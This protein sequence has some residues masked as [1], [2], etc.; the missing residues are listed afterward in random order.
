MTQIDS[1]A[2]PRTIP[3]SFHRFRMFNRMAAHPAIRK[4]MAV[5]FE[6][7]ANAIATP[8]VTGRSGQV[9]E[10]SRVT[11]T[12]A[13]K[14]RWVLAIAARPRIGGRVVK[15]AVAPSA[16]FGPATRRAQRKTTAEAI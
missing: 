11:P 4:G 14:A 16:A 13:H 7:T 12:I 1:A 2:V 5:N 9:W 15:T 3:I 8:R 6:H 10:I